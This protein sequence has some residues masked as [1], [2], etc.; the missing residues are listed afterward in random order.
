MDK[1]ETG[2]I[3]QGPQTRRPRCVW[4]RLNEDGVKVPIRPTESMWY[5][6]YVNNPLIARDKSMYDKFRNRFRL[7]YNNYLELVDMCRNDYRFDK[8]CGVKK[9]KKKASPIELLVLG[10]LRYLGRGFT[11]DDI[12]ECTAIST[13]VHRVFFHVFTDYGR[14]V[15]YPKFVKFPKTRGDATTHMAEFIASGFPGCVG[16][17]DCTHISTE[18]CEYAIRNQHIGQKSSGPTRSFSLTANHRRQILHTSSGG[19]G[20]WNDQT[21]VRHDDFVSGIYHGRYLNDIEFDLYEYDHNRRLAKRTY[22]GAYVIV[23]NGYLRWSVTVPPFKVTNRIDEIRW[24][25][26]VESMRKDVECTFGIL[27]GRFRILKAGVRLDGIN[28]VDN[29]W[30]TCCALHNW[31]LDIDGLTGEWRDGVPVSD[32]EGNMGQHDDDYPLNDTVPNAVTRLHTSLNFRNY[33]TSG[34]GPGSDIMGT[35]R[36]QDDMDDVL[37]EY[38]DNDDEDMPINVDAG[39]TVRI[40]RQLPLKYFRRKLVEHFDIMFHHNQIRWTIR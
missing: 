33:D 2:K 30:F 16:S 25:K 11:F 3:Q 1:P 24:S 23:D 28:A 13:E 6:M 7:P 22:K 12:E 8:W 19:P 5:T 9:N 40:V 17:S 34:M 10:A 20:S 26:W 37:D 31:L 35:I 15:L 27:K 21:M 29:V 39:I 36:N 18:R 4:G 14:Q 38:C 32:W